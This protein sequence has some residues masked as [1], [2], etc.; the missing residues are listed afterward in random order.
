MSAPPL[1]SGCGHRRSVQPLLSYHTE[2]PEACEF[3][4]IEATDQVQEHFSGCAPDKENDEK[5]YPVGQSH[6]HVDTAFPIIVTNPTH[7]GPRADL[8]GLPFYL[9]WQEFNFANGTWKYVI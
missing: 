9:E 5:P 3:T 2:S 4:P 1:A 7:L 6:V 8:K